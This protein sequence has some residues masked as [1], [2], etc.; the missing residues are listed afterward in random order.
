MIKKFH[1]G[2]MARDSAII[3]LANGPTVTDAIEAWMTKTLAHIQAKDVDIPTHC[4]LNR[5][6]VADEKGR[7]HGIVIGVA[8][9]TIPGGIF[10]VNLTQRNTY[11]HYD[12]GGKL[13]TLKEI[14]NG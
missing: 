8:V 4:G 5:Y 7:L 12:I 13:V 11:L 9:N 1:V 10:Q 6:V 3:P 2:T 14:L